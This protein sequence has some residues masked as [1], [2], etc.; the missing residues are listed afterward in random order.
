MQRKLIHKHFRKL[1]VDK[2]VNKKFCSTLKPYINSWKIK[3]NSHIIIKDNEK[4]ISDTKECRN[5]D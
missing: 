1:F 3:N 4:I 5:N 2:H